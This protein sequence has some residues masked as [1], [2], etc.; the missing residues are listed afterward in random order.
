MNSAFYAFAYI[1]FG[2]P[3]LLAWLGA[4]FGTV[5][6]LAGFLAVP[7]ALAVWLRRELRRRVRD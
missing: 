1:G 4:T 7:T 5:P 3:L 2:T 6:A